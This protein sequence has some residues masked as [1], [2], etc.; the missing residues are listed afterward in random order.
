MST[1]N[2]CYVGGHVPRIKGRLVETLKLTQKAGGNTLQMF[3]GS[4]QSVAV[5][6]TEYMAQASEV[7]SYL[8]EHDMKIVIHSPYIINLCKTDKWITERL[9]KELLVAEAMG[10]EGCVVHVGKAVKDN[11][12]VAEERMID[13]VRTIIDRLAGNKMDVKLFVETAAGQMTELFATKDNTLSE[14]QRFKRLLDRDSNDNWG[15]CVDTCHTWTSG[16]DMADMVKHWKRDIGMDRLGVIHMNNSQSAFGA[17]VDRHA[18]LQHGTIPF[19]LLC[20][21]ARKAARREIPLILETPGVIQ[22]IPLLQKMCVS[23][24]PPG[25][26]ELEKF[27]F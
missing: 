11:V 16:Y 23:K 2:H 18:C 10:A 8:K 21:I 27:D 22:E 12:V 6:T 5:N 1:P 7:Q 26:F 4:P 17:H 9:W 3:V 19:P 25:P 14:L 13:N 15:F 24:D 20:A